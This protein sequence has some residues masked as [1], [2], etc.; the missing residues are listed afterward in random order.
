[1]PPKYPYPEHAKRWKLRH[2]EGIIADFLEFLY[3]NGY[4]LQHTDGRE[5][6]DVIQAV[7]SHL[8]LDRD[9]L[10]AEAREFKKRHA[11]Q[12]KGTKQKEQEI[13]GAALLDQL[14]GKDK[15]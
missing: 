13:R 14:F 4:G 10:E 6:V 12:C 3:D 1:M 2:Q 7:F 15:D 5:Q 8:E 9:L 11:D